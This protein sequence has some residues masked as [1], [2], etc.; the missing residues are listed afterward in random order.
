[1]L[2][3]MFC[4]SFWIDLKEAGIIS[5]QTNYRENYGF[6]FTDTPPFPLPQISSIGWEHLSDPDYRWHGLHRAEPN[7][8]LFQYTLSGSGKLMLQ[9]SVHTLQPGEAFMV[10]IPGEHE[11]FFEPSVS[12]WEFI[13][14]MIM[15]KELSRWVDQVTQDRGNV[16]A[17]HSE[18]EIIRCLRQ[19]LEQARNKQIQNIYYSAELAY[20]FF[21]TLLRDQPS[22]QEHDEMPVFIERALQ[23]MN[24]HFKDIES[25]DQISSMAGISKYHFLRQFRKYIHCTPLEYLNRVRIE[26]SAELLRK[27]DMNIEEIAKEVGYSN[28]NYYSKVFRQ[29]VGTTPGKFRKGRDFMPIDHLSIK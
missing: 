9:S 25:L 20:Q 23:Y 2:Y 17:Y 3:I 28:G 27:S 18:S 24:I 14:V 16:Q 10:R 12:H 26:K 15:D 7:H 29:W 5:Y 6:L 19:M 11:Y 13:Y 4:L 8:V 1:M 21:M 22:S